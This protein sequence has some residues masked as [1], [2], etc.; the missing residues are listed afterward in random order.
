MLGSIQAGVVQ[1]NNAVL[2]GMRRS[3]RMLVFCRNVEALT[4]AGVHRLKK[5]HQLIVQIV[6]EE[7]VPEPNAALNRNVSSLLQAIEPIGKGRRVREQKQLRI[8]PAEFYRR[9]G[10]NKLANRIDLRSKL[11]FLR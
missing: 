4:P 8:V 3:K 10:Y 11:T 1:Q 7:N 6:F 2:K 9:S 5:H